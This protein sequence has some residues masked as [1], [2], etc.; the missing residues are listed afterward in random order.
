MNNKIIG[1]LFNFGGEV[2]TQVIH[3]SQAGKYK[4][5][6]PISPLPPLPQVPMPSSMAVA[7][8]PAPAVNPADIIPPD[9]KPALTESSNITSEKATGVKS[10]CIPCAVGHLGTC[11]GVLNEAVRFAGDGV[12][13]PEVID[14]INMCLDEANALE[15][16]DLRPAMIEAL[17]PWEKAL[18]SKALQSSRNLRHSLEAIQTPED[19]MHAAASAEGVRKDIGR[20]WFAHKIETLPPDLKAKINKEL[21]ALEK[22]QVQHEHSHAEPSQ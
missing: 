7:P 13:N 3:V 14:R 19:L 15:R 18:A 12:N 2:L 5:D 22:K 1:S 17:P 9:P 20:Q 10:G 8:S 11:S 6:V 16:V 4:L 21:D